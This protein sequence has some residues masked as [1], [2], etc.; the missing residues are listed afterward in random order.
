MTTIKKLLPVDIYDVDV[1]ERY[2]ENMSAKGY[3]IERIGILAHYRKGEPRSRK[4]QLEP[5][6]RQETAP[7]QE[8]QEAYSEAGWDYVCTISG[9]FHLYQANRDSPMELHT[10][11]VTQG[12]IYQQLEKKLRTSF[13]IAVVILPLSVAM[14]LCSVF[15]NGQPLLYAVRYGQSVAMGILALLGIY[16]T[17]TTSQRMMKIHRMTEQLKTGIP[18]SRKKS[19]RPWRINSVV[20]VVTLLLASYLLLVPI[21]SMTSKW[22]ALLTDYSGKIP[23]IS[24][25]SME[26][27][28][29][30]PEP[31]SDGNARYSNS[32]SYSWSDM[33]PEQYTIR[34]RGV[35]PG[36]RWDDN[37]GEYSPSLTTEFYRLRFGFLAEPLLEELLEKE[38]VFFRYKPIMYRELLDSAFDRA[39]V[40]KINESQMLFGASGSKVI[41]C[42]YHGYGDLEL[43]LDEIY[44]AVSKF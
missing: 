9:L 44:K 19:R 15:L 3:F 27:E 20:N 13:W 25:S 16:E 43:Y 5:L 18:I 6:T 28:G 38:L 21:Y 4:Y 42:S 32:I 22:D 8:A 34:E 33:A 23:T 41:Y 14:I 11:P 37:S 26:E 7:P 39:I 1:L 36:R 2:F 30:V 29:F 12:Y 40:V 10:D 35:I 17:L 24:L 31:D